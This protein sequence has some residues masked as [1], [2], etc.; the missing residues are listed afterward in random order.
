[1]KRKLI[2]N[3]VESIQNVENSFGVE[4]DRLEKSETEKLEELLSTSVLESAMAFID[5]FKRNEDFRS[6]NVDER[7]FSIKSNLLKIVLMEN[8][9]RRKSKMKNE[10][11]EIIRSDRSVLFL[12]FLVALFS[13]NR[14]DSEENFRFVSSKKL[15]SKENF[16]NDLFFK[17]CLKRYDFDR[18]TRIYSLLV[19]KH[20]E[21]QRFID[22]NRFSIDRINLPILIQSIL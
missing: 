3:E 11:I 15:L 22:E 4:T 17:H 14:F 10:T 2:L 16:C 7:M 8:S 13:S 21:F 20:I 18:T 19:A 9:I 6:L 5:A 12:F 1:M